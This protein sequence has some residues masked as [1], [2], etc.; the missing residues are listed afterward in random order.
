MFRLAA[1]VLLTLSLIACAARSDT[2]ALSPTATYKID[3]LPHCEVASDLPAC[4]DLSLTPEALPASGLGTLD[5]LA[6]IY[7][8]PDV[9]PACSGESLTYTSD[10]NRVVYTVVGADPE[11]GVFVV[12]ADK[13]ASRFVRVVER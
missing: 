1:T 13:N 2:C 3:L 10:Q 9:T 8:G 12:M 6:A 4:A 7:V 5:E 11:G